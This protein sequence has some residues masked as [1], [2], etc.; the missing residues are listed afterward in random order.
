MRERGGLLSIA[1]SM[2]D[3]DERDIRVTITDDGQGI[4]QAHRERVFEP[5]FTTKTDGSG[6]GLGLS[7]VRSIVLS[8]G[9]RISAAGNEPRGTVFHLELPTA[10]SPSGDD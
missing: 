1:T 4:E 5:F 2:T 6:T 7:I 10:A 3:G 8:H 9:G